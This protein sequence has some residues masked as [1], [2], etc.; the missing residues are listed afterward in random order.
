MITIL[1]FQIEGLDGYVRVEIDHKI[2]IKRK[3]DV[4]EMLNEEINLCRKI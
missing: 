2:S 3:E 1:N 4:D